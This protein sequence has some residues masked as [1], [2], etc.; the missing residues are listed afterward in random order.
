MPLELSGEKKYKSRATTPFSLNIVLLSCA[1]VD[2]L[3]DIVQSARLCQLSSATENH[4]KPSGCTGRP[5][6]YLVLCEEWG[7][8]SPAISRSNIYAGIEK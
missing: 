2:L 6:P 1:I 3:L 5:G 8:M 4:T 7:E